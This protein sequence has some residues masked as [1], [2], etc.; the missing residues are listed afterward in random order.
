M[1]GLPKTVIFCSKCTLSNQRPVPVAE[2]KTKNISEKKG[3][4]IDSKLICNAC[5]FAQKKKEINWKNREKDLIKICDKFR[6]KKKDKYDCIVPGSGGKD[7]RYASYILKYK[8]GMNPL[9]VTWAPHIYTEIGRKNMTSW[10]DH[11][12]NYLITPNR[13]VQRKLSR[14]SFL[15][16][17][18]PFQ[19]FVLGQRFAAIRT[20][21]N[22]DI[23]LVFH[24]ESPFEYGVNNLKEADTSGFHQNYFCGS[25]NPQKI[26]LGGKSIKNLISK[27]K[28]RPSDLI[29]YL[30]IS[31]NELKKFKF[32][33]KFL[34]HYVKWNP[35]EIFY[36]VS[37]NTG[38]LPNPE[39]TE[40][41]YSKYASLDDKMDGF[42]YYTSFIKFGLGRA[43]M[44][45]S[46]EIRNDL[47]DRNEGIS[48]VK[49][50]DGEFPIKYFEEILD[51]L[52]LS[53]DQFWKTIDKFRSQHLWIKKNKKWKLKNKIY[54]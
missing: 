11:V 53:R 10:V 47:L 15:N 19:P 44:D 45:T 29:N 54:E 43:T 39:R 12:D 6:S 25:Q 50:Y 49:K 20:A 51:Y 30:P 36:F 21:I 22:M 14:E 41:T 7:S 40:G 33:Y 27:Y 32:H 3:N 31:K 18:H 52:N 24:G 13:D 17:L 35:Q 37:K 1:F 5:K 26:F 23:K 28:F 4:E 34:G 16:L 2:F 42:H 9:T 38:F 46:Q 48:L 8:Y